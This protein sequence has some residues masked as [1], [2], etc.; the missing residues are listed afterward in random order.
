MAVV[1]SYGMDAQL[2]AVL[3]SWTVNLSSYPHPG[4]VPELV[5]K[6]RQFFVDVTCAE[7]DKCKAIA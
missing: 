4:V 6:P 5:Y 1:L 7:N 2:L 3:L